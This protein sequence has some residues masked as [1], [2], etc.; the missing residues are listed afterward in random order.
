MAWGVET[1]I[2]GP[3]GLTGPQGAIGPT[4]PP[5]PTGPG[6]TVPG[7]PGA[8][9]PPGS[10]GPAGPQGPQ[11][12]PGPAGSGAGDMLKSENL[13]GLL[14]YATARS[15]LGLGT[16]AVA[17]DAPSDGTIYGRKNA[18]WVAGG[19]GGSA[20]YVADTPPAG[21][22]DS[23]L[24]YE[25]DSAGLFIRY[26]D[27]TSTQWVAAAPAGPAGP[28]GPTGAAGSTGSQGPQGNPGA[29][30][31][32]GPQGPAGPLIIPASWLAGAAPNNVTLF[33][34]SRALTITAI[35]GVVE[36]ANGAAATVSVVKA[37]SGTALSAGTVVHSGS[38]NAN[39]TA[40]TNQ[41]LTPTVTALATGDRLGLTST[42]TFTASVGSIS[43][44]VQ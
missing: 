40:A 24:W 7:P 35:V 12:L 36:T 3:P 10:T 23:S 42:G 27:G 8:T 15:N 32:Q 17:N 18:T 34:A 4:G 43:V 33:I 20:I 26:N 22:P 41:T 28:A 37:A 16:I 1:N 6:S 25:G 14:N 44:T 11:G 5:G 19:G 9:G 38:F 2:K 39:G 29:T 31:S 13:L 30:G 21:A